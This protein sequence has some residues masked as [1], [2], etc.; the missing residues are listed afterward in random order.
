MSVKRNRRHEIEASRGNNK[1]YRGVI[2]KGG[3]DVEGG[4]G[5]DSSRGLQ[6]AKK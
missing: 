5:S 1:K 3:K 6:E 4:K 2:K